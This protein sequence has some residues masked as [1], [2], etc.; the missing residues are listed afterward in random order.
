MKIYEYHGRY[1]EF[2]FSGR[3]KDS[4]KGWIDGVTYKAY[5][6]QGIYTREKED[7]FKKFRLVESK[8]EIK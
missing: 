7:F 1:Y 4:V 6:Q 8:N 2:I 3:M 5:A